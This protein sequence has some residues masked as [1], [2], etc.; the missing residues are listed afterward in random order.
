ML[1]ICCLFIS[2]V[3]YKTIS[4][5]LLSGTFLG[6]EI[7]SSVLDPFLATYFVIREVRT[8]FEKYIQHREYSSLTVGANSLCLQSIGNRHDLFAW[9]GL[10]TN[11]NCPHST[12]FS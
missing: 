5:S 7:V 10:V 6:Q 3:H 12:S 1:W 2:Y 9:K 8:Q 11:G 4:N